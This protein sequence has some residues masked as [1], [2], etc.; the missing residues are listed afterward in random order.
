MKKDLLSVSDLESEEIHSLIL[1]AVEMKARG[2]LSLLSR[3]V[4]AI[5]F[6]SRHYEPALALRWQCASWAG[7][8]FIYLRLK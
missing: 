2:W 5:M 7:K 6:V 4:L 1:D 3:K 8:A